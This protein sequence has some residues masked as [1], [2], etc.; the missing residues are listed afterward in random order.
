MK[1]PKII[2]IIVAIVG[3]IAWQASRK[4]SEDKVT[5]GIIQ[6]ASH[7]ALDRAR[8]GF[9]KHMREQLGEGVRFKEQNAEGS[10]SQAQ[11]IAA[12]YHANRQIKAIYAIG[13]L[14]AQA[15]LRAEKQKPILIAAVS[16]PEGAGL[17]QNN[18][19]GTSDKV[20]AQK[21]IELIRRTLPKATKI[22]LLHNPAEQNS[23]VAIK[24]M[25]KAAKDAGLQTV[26]VGVQHAS[27]VVTATRQ[28]A[29][30]ADAILVPTDNLLV[31][32]MPTVARVAIESKTPLFVSDPPSVENGALACL[33]IDYERAGRT[34]AE[35]ALRVLR[36]ETPAQ[37]AIAY[38]ND[39]ALHVNAQTSQA[40]DVAVVKP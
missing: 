39:P 27:E 28:A 8:E 18:V 7:P 40:I 20:P 26:E 38:E 30:I 11:T 34:T 6:T 25:S 12:S 15:A 13:T 9:I 36:G 1:C 31:S 3:L 16:D 29:K 19:S 4:L 2:L 10:V 23:V 22:A 35:I 33:G 14:A 17:L 5:I 37:I 24:E 21:Q 32:A